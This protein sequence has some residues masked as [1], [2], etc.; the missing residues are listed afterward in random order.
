MKT[1]PV[2]LP[3]ALRAE[4]PTTKLLWAYLRPQGVV[5][6]TVRGMAEA[7]GASPPSVA[8][9]MRQLETLKLLRYVGE[10][11]PRQRRA[12]EVL[13]EARSR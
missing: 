5:S 9:G 4:K 11:Q 13:G 6:Y 2:R 8:A 12:F 10:R 1:K 7:L 3:E